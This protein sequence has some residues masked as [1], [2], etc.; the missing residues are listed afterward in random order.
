[1]PVSPID[2]SS[3]ARRPAPTGTV[4]SPGANLASFRIEASDAA[5][6]DASSN[7]RSA[8]LRPRGDYAAAA[9]RND[10]VASD[11]ADAARR[12]AQDR[13][14]AR[15]DDAAKAERAERAKSARSTPEARQRAAAPQVR[16]RVSTADRQ[17][18]AETV[19][20][21]PP[22]AAGSSDETSNADAASDDGKAIPEDGRASEDETKEAALGAAQMVL[23]PAVAPP[24][25][26]QVAA[27]LG[28]GAAQSGSGKPGDLSKAGDDIAGSVEA[29]MTP[30]VKPDASALTGLPALKVAAEND[31]AGAGDQPFAKAE[32]AFAEALGAASDATARTD[33][34]PSS[35]ANPAP[36]GARGAEPTAQNPASAQASAPVPLGAVP[37]TIGLR[38]LAGSNQFEIRL[39]P[40]DL[41]RIDVNLDIDKAT[42][43]VQAHL[44]VDRPETLALLQR[45][46]ANLQQ[47]LAQAGLSAG[48]GSIN[49]SLRGDGAASGQSNGSGADGGASDR[50]GAARAGSHASDVIPSLTAVPMRRYGALLGI[51]IRI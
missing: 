47:A 19:G 24:P 11:R 18:T 44:V 25:A 37:M 1:M 8:A 33:L 23:A 29:R 32:G 40:K 21:P 48:D 26:T 2:R 17:E 50:H 6:R 12:A 30:V 46:A 20:T 41:G 14:D 39:D 5:S 4:P 51:D 15:Q 38:S 34:A 35:V 9:T 27:A 49:L 28:A 36:S 10:R 45:D 13:H 3:L 43:A 31:G 16:D 7:L 22:G 42:G